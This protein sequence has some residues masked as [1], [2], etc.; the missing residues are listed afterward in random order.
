M[1][2]LDKTHK[3]DAEH[4]ASSYS[5][6]QDELKLAMKQGTTLLSCIKDQASKNENHKLNPD[7]MENLT[8]VERWDKYLFCFLWGLLL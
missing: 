7:E 4:D 6:F 8:T 3:H 5:V 1:E 2:K